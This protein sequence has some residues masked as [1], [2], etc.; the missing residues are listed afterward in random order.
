MLQLGSSQKWPEQLKLVTGTDKMDVQPLLDY[1]EPLEKYLDEV[2]VDQTIG[3]T[4]SGIYCY[5]I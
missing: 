4:A 3:W 1:F 5:I 2:L